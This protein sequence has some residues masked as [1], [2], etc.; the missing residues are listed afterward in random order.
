MKLGCNTVGFRRLELED[1][2]ERVRRAGYRYVEVESNLSWCSHVDPWNDDP[3]KFGE[4][5]GRMGFAGV[6]GMGSHRELISDPDAVSDLKQALRW[7][8][9]AG[10]PVVITGEGRC[11]EGMPEEEALAIIGDRLAQ[12]V[13][14]AEASGVVLAM[15]PHGTISLS[16]MGL[17]HIMGLASSP[18]FGVNFDTANP[19]RGDYVGTTRAGY[20]WKLDE[21]R[22]GDEVEVLA[23]VAPLVRHVHAKDVVGRRAVTLGTGEVDLPRCLEMLAK[24]GFDGVLSY[25]TEGEDPPEKTEEM[26]AESRR[27]LE[28]TLEAI[29]AA[30]TM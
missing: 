28:R 6:S 30:V 5:V 22:R 19:H 15:E 9:K 24:C 18:C 3:S 4:T 2:L 23:S 20:E 26:M 17:A 11:P 13:P 12:L 1:A 25:E 14:A 7:A 16:S 10:V 8:S 29:G 27:Y 21:S